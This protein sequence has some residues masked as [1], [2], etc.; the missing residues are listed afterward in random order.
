[1]KMMKRNVF[2]VLLAVIFAAFCSISV[3]ADFV[4]T[5]TYTAGQ[6]TDVDESAWYASNVADAYEISLMNGCGDGMFS[7]ETSITIAEAVTMAAR[8][9]AMYANEEIPSVPGEWYAPYVAYAVR[10]GITEEYD[11]YD[12]PAM[13]SEVASFFC[14]ALPKEWYTSINEVALI[15][16]VPESAAFYEDLLTLFRAGIVMGSDSYGNFY[17][18]N[19]ITRAE[20]AAVIAR[21]VLPEQRLHKSLDKTVREDAYK[22]AITTQW[23]SLKQGR[24]NSGW[25]LDNRGGKPRTTLSETYTTVMDIDDEAPTALIRE[26][27]TVST[28]VL[29][30]RT[31][32]LVVGDGVYLEFRSESEESVFRLITKDGKWMLSTASGDVSVYEIAPFEQDFTF[33][34][35][36]DID[37]ARTC[38]VINGKEAG[39]FALPAVSSRNVRCFRIASTDEGIGSYH[40]RRFTIFANYAV[41]ENF[42]FCAENETPFGFTLENGSVTGEKL[43]LQNN[44]VLGKS[45]LPLGGDGVVE[46]QCL[47]PQNEHIRSVLS[48]E[49]REIAVLTT[50][51]TCIYLNG[52]VVYQNH[53]PNL[54]Y[55][56]RMEFDA[57]NQTINV[58][59]NGRTCGV[60]SFAA[61]CSTLDAFTFASLSETP[62]LFDKLYIFRTWQ[63]A[64][65]VPAPIKPRGEEIYNIGVNV[66]SLW[67]NGTADG[68][69]CITPYDDI[70]PLLGYYD[71]T[72]PETAD[73]EIKYM[74]EH[75]IDFQAFCVFFAE[76][77]G[78]VCI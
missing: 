59:I 65:Y 32:V 44:G 78:T 39:T 20:A 48:S 35:T 26:F 9:S 22:L 3:S 60:V 50:D 31:R 16:D 76:R 67:M 55:R 28:G 34:I 53:V 37:N 57:E 38:V 75:G 69:S 61:P 15:P 56:F 74:V 54:W 13:R 33:F 29:D 46:F 11:D 1:M 19:P 10:K 51:D 68:W 14:K 73:W 7:P 64:D 70:R 66:C 58:K 8:V 36:L 17:P 24:I 52:T 4:R 41:S 49:G 25:L 30:V 12:I 62:I 63:H 6:F 40:P 27:N 47:L 18:Y 21:T 45:F 72:V 5:Q 42:D 23:D 2:A 77:E 71:E 43:Q